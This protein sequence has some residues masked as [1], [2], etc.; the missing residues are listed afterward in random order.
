M[1]GTYVKLQQWQDMYAVQ[2]CRQP[3]P[4]RSSAGLWTSSS[5]YL[6]KFGPALPAG[7][8]LAQGYSRQRVGL[9]GLAG[10]RGKTGEDN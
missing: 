5:Q 10:F 3:L 2:E 8:A 1:L 6:Q 4:E 7:T 9:E